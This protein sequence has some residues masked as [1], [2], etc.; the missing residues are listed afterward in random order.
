MIGLYTKN[1][2]VSGVHFWTTRYAQQRKNKLYHFTLTTAWAKNE[3]TA[4]L[5]LYLSI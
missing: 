1:I 4:H 3:A 2:N 5:C